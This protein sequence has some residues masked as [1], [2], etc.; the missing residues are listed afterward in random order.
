MFPYPSL[1]ET[2][3]KVARHF[4]EKGCT[5][6]LPRFLAEIAAKIS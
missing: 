5:K 6:F 1:L 3:E 4:F 2:V